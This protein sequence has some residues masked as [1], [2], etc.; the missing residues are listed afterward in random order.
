VVDADVVG[1]LEGFGRDGPDGA[2]E[3]AEWVER[4]VRVVPLASR[5]RVEQVR[6]VDGL[7]PT[8]HRA[9]RFSQV[10][11]SNLIHRRVVP[12]LLREVKP[13]LVR[14]AHAVGHALW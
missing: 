11:F 4:V 1:D 13:I 5:R 10:G 8:E 3:L 12:A 6:R 14:P 2:G 9:V 7:G